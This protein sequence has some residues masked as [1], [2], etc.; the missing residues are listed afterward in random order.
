MARW[1]ETQRGIVGAEDCDVKGAFELGGVVP[2][3][4]NRAEY[5]AFFDLGDVAPST[6]ILDCAAGPSSFNAEIT[7]AGFRVISVDPLYEH[8]AESIRR[9]CAGA[10]KAMIEG[11]RKARDRF[12]WDCLRSPEHAAEVRRVTLDTFLGDYEGGRAEGRYRAAALPDLPF[13]DRVFDLALCSHFLF[14]Y[15]HDLDASFHLAAIGEMV[16]VGG[17]ARV[18]PLLDMDGQPSGHVEPV[19]GALEATGYA[20]SIETVDYEFQRGG[21]EMLRV[22]RRKVG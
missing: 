9:V 21:N 20:T 18:F 19:R 16:R 8:D 17:E 2:W 11:M 14:L 3:G 13:D 5:T 22:T 12:V 4:R 15:S 6:R 10:S 1:I 7:R